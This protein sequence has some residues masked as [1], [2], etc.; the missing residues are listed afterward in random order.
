MNQLRGKTPDDQIRSTYE[1]RRRFR[2]FYLGGTIV[3]FLLLGLIYSVTGAKHG[4][5]PCIGLGIFVCVSVLDRMNWRCPSC[6]KRLGR[7]GGYGRCPHCGV[8]LGEPGRGTISTGQFLIV[9]LL[10]AIVTVV[11]LVL[12]GTK[13]GLV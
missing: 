13:V 1:G 4:V 10:L 3:S 6:D 9:F 12:S 8:Y 2:I 11:V 5:L 7:Y